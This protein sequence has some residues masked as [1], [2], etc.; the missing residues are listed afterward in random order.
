MFKNIVVA[1][2][3]SERDADAVALAVR[4]RGPSGRLLLATVVPHADLGG[5]VG[6]FGYDSYMVEDATKVLDHAEQLAGPD[7]PDGRSL[8]RDH[9]P[10]HALDGLALDIGADLMVLGSTHR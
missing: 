1:C 5:R 3:G 2:D 4:L 7:L 9:S 6:D 10:A 8:L